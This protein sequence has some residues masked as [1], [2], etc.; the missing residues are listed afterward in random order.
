MFKK[1]ESGNPTG[2]PTGAKNKIQLHI[3]EKIQQIVESNLPN[4]GGWIEQ[5]AQRDPAK[6][7]E[8]TS[9]LMEYVLPKMK[10]VEIKGEVEPINQVIVVRDQETADNLEKLQKLLN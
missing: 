6:A 2:R 3:K 8:M 1:G 4:L 5:V 9:K 7:L 10:A